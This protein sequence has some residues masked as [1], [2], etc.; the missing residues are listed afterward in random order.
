MLVLFLSIGKIVNLVFQ[1]VS[2]LCGLM[3]LMGHLVCYFG[4][5]VQCFFFSSVDELLG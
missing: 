5:N 2:F 4:A 3:G 1:I